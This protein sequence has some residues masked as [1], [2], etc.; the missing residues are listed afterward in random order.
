MK[1]RRLQDARNLLESKEYEAVLRLLAALET[2]FPDEDEVRRLRESARNEQSEQ[3]KRECLAEA[4]KF[5]VAGQYEKSIATLQ[6]LQSDFPAEAEIGRLLESTRQEQSEHRRQEGL[7]EAR[8]LLR[9]KRYADSITVLEKLHDEFPAET[10]IRKQLIIAREELAEQEKQKKLGEARNLLAAQ[11]F[12]EALKLLNNLA[13]IYPKDATV[14]KL[15]TLAQRE[16]EKFARAERIQS[17]LNDLKKLMG[18]RKYREVITR[19]KSVL[20]EFPGEAHFIRLAEFATSQQETIEREALLRTVLDDVR[21]HFAA[22]RFEEAA[23]AAKRASTPAARRASVRRRWSSS[24]RPQTRRSA[25]ASSCPRARRCTRRA[26]S[27]A[28]RIAASA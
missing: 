17:E 5:L 21:S 25:R 10:E 28:P 4:R 26:R 12:V 13:E 22:N 16:Q 19:T 3:R 20:A 11:S 27:A 9:A 18:E 14:L 7:A 6:K 2:E 24:P 8:S 23:R 15:R 1:Q